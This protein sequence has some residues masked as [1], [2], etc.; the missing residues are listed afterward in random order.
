VLHTQGLSELSSMDII[1]GDAIKKIV[2]TVVP[3]GIRVEVPERK[4]LIK[5]TTGYD[6]NMILFLVVYC[7]DSKVLQRDE[8]DMYRHCVESEVGKYLPLRENRLGRLVSRP[9]PYYLLRSIID[10]HTS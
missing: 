3:D 2:E 6:F 8:A 4:V 10:D 1:E 5:E 9:F 7:G